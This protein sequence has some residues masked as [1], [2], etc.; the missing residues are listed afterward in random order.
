MTFDPSIPAD[1]IKVRYLANAMRLQFQAFLAY[2]DSRIT[3]PFPSG[4]KLFFYQDTA[5][6]GW[7]I[8]SNVSDCL[9]GVK[10]GDGTGVYQTAGTLQGTWQQADHVLSWGQMPKH[11]H[12]SSQ[13]AQGSGRYSYEVKFEYNQSADYPFGSVA[14][15]DEP[16]NHG[17]TWRP[18]AAVGIIAEKD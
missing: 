6:P 8:A 3:P 13:Y 9:L 15:N 4:T 18:M 17:N 10:T 1:N 16:H 5:P 2:V 12:Y 11:Q 7:T 14:G